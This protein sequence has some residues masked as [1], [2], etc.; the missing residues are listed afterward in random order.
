MEYKNS[1][2]QSVESP[3]KQ[4]ERKRTLESLN[5]YEQRKYLR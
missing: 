5:K 2:Q 4:S 3:R 1:E